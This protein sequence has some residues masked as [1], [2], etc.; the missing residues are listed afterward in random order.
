MQTVFLPGRVVTATYE[1]TV[2]AIMTA[3]A[4]GTPGAQATGTALATRTPHPVATG[5]P[6]PTMTATRTATPVPLLTVSSFQL[7][8]S[9]KTCSSSQQITNNSSQTLG[10]Q[11]QQSEPPG[12]PSDFQWSLNGSPVSD[13]WPPLH[14]ALAS[15]APP[16][17]LVV[18]M[19]CT[20]TT[21]NLTLTD[22]LGRTVSFTMTSQ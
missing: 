6:H 15:A 7:S 22:S 13:N 19:S 11:W 17:Q 2:A 1:P 4:Q 12:I 18:S 9:G 10:W 8:K 14:S 21:Y 16:D 3:I 5:T 20:R